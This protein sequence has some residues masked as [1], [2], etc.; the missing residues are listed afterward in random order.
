MNSRITEV[1][2]KEV[3]RRKIVS[4]QEKFCA[5]LLL[6]DHALREVWITMSDAA[7]TKQKKIAV[8]E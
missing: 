1:V 2:E 8:K 4:D 3:N 7:K 6:L 5:R